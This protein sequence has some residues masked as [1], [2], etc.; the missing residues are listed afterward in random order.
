[1]SQFFQITSWLSFFLFLIIVLLSKPLAMM[2]G[3]IK[4]YP[5]IMAGSLPLLCTPLLSVYRGYY[6]S[7]GELDVTAKSQVVEQLVRVM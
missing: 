1:M 3:E 6:Q 4:L 5:V 7:Q 2:M